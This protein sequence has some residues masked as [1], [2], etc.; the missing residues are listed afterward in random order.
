MSLGVGLW[1][2]LSH[3]TRLSGMAGLSLARASVNGGMPGG[4][5]D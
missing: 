1:F 5:G 4:S 3:R 2:L